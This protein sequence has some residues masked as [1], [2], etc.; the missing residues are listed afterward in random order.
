M[1]KV[2]ASSSDKATAVT[3]RGPAVI[4]SRSALVW[5]TCEG[6]P[7]DYFVGPGEW[8]DLGRPGRIVAEAMVPGDWDVQEMT[9]RLPGWFRWRGV[10]VEPQP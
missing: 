1:R 10:G 2:P 4:R 9:P 7:A 3:V 5:V 8:L 6:D